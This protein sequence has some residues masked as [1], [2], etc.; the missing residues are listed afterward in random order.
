MLMNLFKFLWQNIKKLLIIS[1]SATDSQFWQ[2]IQSS[3]FEYKTIF[4]MRE[5]EINECR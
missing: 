3:H 2:L 5:V 4:Y 1:Y